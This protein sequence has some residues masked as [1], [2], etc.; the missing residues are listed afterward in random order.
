[1]TARERIVKCLTFSSPDRVP[2]DLWTLP[3][4]LL[5][6]GE[7]YDALLGEYPVDIQRSQVSPGSSDR[8]NDSIRETGSYRDEWGSTWSVGEPGVGAGPG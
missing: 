8:M 2:R 6:Q 3:A 5:F 4:V 1:M 7:E